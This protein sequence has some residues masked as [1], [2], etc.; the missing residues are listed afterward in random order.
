MNYDSG[1]VR[2]LVAAAKHLCWREERKAHADFFWNM[3]PGQRKQL[4][5]AGACPW[6]GAMDPSLVH[7]MNVLDEMGEY[8]GTGL[9][10]PANVG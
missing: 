2:S 1:D 7:L 4:G 6:R 3:T 9:S 8:E 10:A 5:I